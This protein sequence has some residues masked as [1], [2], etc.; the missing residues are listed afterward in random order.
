MPLQGLTIFCKRKK[1]I[2]NYT[3]QHATKR[4]GRCYQ[5][6]IYNS[7][8]YYEVQSIINNESICISLVS[9]VGGCVTIVISVRNKKITKNISTKSRSYPQRGTPKS[10]KPGFYALEFKPLSSLLYTTFKHFL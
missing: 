8:R 1:G 10:F 7:T 6:E 4:E 9:S 2:R 5:Y 3:K